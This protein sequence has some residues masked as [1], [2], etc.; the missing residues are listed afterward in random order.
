MESSKLP[1]LPVT[2]LGSS[3]RRKKT[4]NRPVSELPPLPVSNANSNLPVS[5]SGR[6]TFKEPLSPVLDDRFAKEIRS[7]V[8]YELPKIAEEVKSREEFQTRKTG[9][10]INA[11]SAVFGVNASPV[12][13]ALPPVSNLGDNLN[14]PR[15]N[16]PLGEVSIPRLP[17]AQ[18]YETNKTLETVRRGAISALPLEPQAA[19]QPTFRRGKE[20]SSLQRLVA[21]MEVSG[22]PGNL[23]ESLATI[24]SPANLPGKKSREATPKVKIPRL[25]V[26]AARP[27]SRSTK[28]ARS[29]F[30]ESE[31]T[32]V[33]AIPVTSPSAMNLAKTTSLNTPDTEIMKNIMAIDLDKLTA[34]KGLKRDASYNVQE[35]KA[36]AGS[37]NLPKSGNKKELVERI[38]AE[39]LKVNPTAFNM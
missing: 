18:S 19:F 13:S 16:V 22:Q 21:P 28:T 12:L 37:L 8:K 4:T 5:S 35:L 27:S 34:E 33:P 23:E 6:S 15:R 36:I 24:A 7:E 11:K 1:P 14:L 26:T 10:V 29:T 32:I 9:E 31:A 30:T 39:I 38:K 17:T 25:G 2:P 3:S 20:E